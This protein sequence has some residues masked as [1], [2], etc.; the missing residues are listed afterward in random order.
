MT[1]PHLA[2][3]CMITPPPLMVIMHAR[4]TLAGLA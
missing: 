1:G 2:R 3:A 4:A